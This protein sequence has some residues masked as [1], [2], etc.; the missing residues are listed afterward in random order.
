L[1]KSRDNGYSKNQS[2]NSFFLLLH[3]LVVL[4]VLF[5]PSVPTVVKIRTPPTRGG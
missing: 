2:A 1:D 5:V 4:W 3:G